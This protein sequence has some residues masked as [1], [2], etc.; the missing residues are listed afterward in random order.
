MPACRPLPLISAQLPRRTI[1]AAL[2]IA[3]AMW[4]GARA[5]PTLKLRATPAQTEGPFYPLALP[6]DADFDLLRNGEQNY[7]K[8]QAAWVEG[9]VKDTNGKPMAGA[10]VDIWQCGCNGAARQQGDWQ[11]ERAAMWHGLLLSRLYDTLAHAEV[12][13]TRRHLQNPSA[14]RLPGA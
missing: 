2:V 5:Q 7:P 8:G 10:Q 9:V 4:L 12:P 1:A 13:K 11:V 3:P 14:R 6:K